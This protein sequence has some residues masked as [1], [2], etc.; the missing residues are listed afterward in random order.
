MQDYFYRTPQEQRFRDLR[1]IFCGREKCSALHSWGPA[2]RPNYIIHYILEGKGIYQMGSESWELRE[3]EGFLIEPEVQTF[4]QADWN[5]PWTYCWIGFD[6]NLVPALLGELGLGGDRLTFWCD[7]KEELKTLFESI[8]RHQQY[9]EVNDLILESLLYQFFAILIGDSQVMSR[10]LSGKRNDYVQGT[11]QYIR[12]NYFRPIKVKD[13]T[14]YAGINRSYLYSLFMNE[15][16]MSPSDYLAN[17]RLTRA[18]EMLKL[19]SYSIESIAHSCGYQ[20]AQVFSKAF[21]QKYQITPLKF[22]RE[23]YGG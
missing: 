20:D 12:N 1:L 8:L 6:G 5:H 7:K 17:F 3:G 14:A 19:T 21:K 15:V 4:Y 9:S 13:M 16:G 22:R 11:I 10:E 23:E 18:A 2:V